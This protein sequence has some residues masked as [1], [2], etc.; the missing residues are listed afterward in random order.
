MS[1]MVSKICKESQEP[2][3]VS[4]LLYDP[5]EEADFLELV[6]I[7]NKHRQDYNEAIE[8]FFGISKN[9]IIEHTKFNHSC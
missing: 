8:T 5:G 3:Q 4:T 9:V 7:S 1:K 6:S 2:H